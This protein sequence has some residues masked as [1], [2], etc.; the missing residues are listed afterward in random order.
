MVNISSYSLPQMTD[1]IKRSFL[2]AQKSLPQV[3]RNSSFVVSDVLPHGTWDTRRYAQRIHRTQYAGVR[4]EWN[5]SRQAQVQY[6]YEKDLQVYTISLETSITKHMRDTGKNPEIIAAITD[7]SEVCPNT[8]DLDLAHRLT[9]ARATS[10]TRTAWWTSTTIDTTMW[11]TLALVS[12]VH[13]L[14]GSA[15]TFSNQIA[16][17]PQ[18]SKWALENAEKLFVEET[19]DNLW[20]KMAMTADTIVTTDDPNTIH[21]VRELLNAEAN[22][23]TSNAATF[24]VFKN[25]YKHVIVPR[26]ATTGTGATDT[27]KRK[28]RFLIA[29]RNSSFY[30]TILNEPYTKAPAD[31][32][33]GEEFSSE[34]WNYLT[35]SSYGIA[36]VSPERVK[37]SKWDGSS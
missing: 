1:L 8:I 25:A 37:W 33:N 35:A 30:F 26:I 23:D 17:N 29:S 36:I 32:N 31:W 13:T 9:F 10:Y 18:F 22:V 2:Y 15:T 3:M 12:T 14:T 24:N 16:G 19:Y 21:Q 34:N 4:D 27:T 5:T 28:Y 7:L 6:G 20:I 11:D